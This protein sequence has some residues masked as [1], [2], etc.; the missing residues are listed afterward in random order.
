[1]LFEKTL[2]ILQTQ[3]E[4]IFEK[5][6]SSL[7]QAYFLIRPPL[8]HSQVVE[9]NTP[10][11]IKPECTMLSSLLNCK[12]SKRYKSLQFQFAIHFFLDG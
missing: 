11:L 5:I 7:I 2:Y 10:L 4:L 9:G 6:K 12:E 8:L 1:M 3:I